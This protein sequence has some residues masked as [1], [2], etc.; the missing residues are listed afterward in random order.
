MSY[1]SII[2]ELPEDLRMVMLRLVEAVQRDMREQFAVR[3]EDFEH[4]QG[5][6]AQ[7]A[8]AYEHVEE[9]LTRLETAVVELAEA[10]KRSEER[11]TRLETAVVELAEAQKRSE[12]RLTRLETVVGRLETVVVELAEVQKRAEERLGSLEAAVITMTAQLNELT[13]VVKRA[14]L[15]EM[16]GR[17]LEQHYRERAAAYFG[18]VLR[19]V[20]VV[21]WSEI[22][23][24]VDERLSQNERNDL[25][26][27][28]LLVRGK[29]RTR[30]E[31][32][33]VWVALEV[34]GQVEDYDVVRAQ[35]RAAILQR[36]GYASVPAVAGE[37][38]TSDGE[39]SAEAANVVVI[40]NGNMR[41]WDEALAKMPPV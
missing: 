6:V 16:R 38:I 12:E 36:L 7:L 19:R 14:R 34:S 24:E 8:G 18:N 10:Q 20:R 37:E 26:R 4:L 2:E 39:L 21:P 30:P 29:S 32:P 28:D 41:F 31:L 1:L 5:V 27:L 22:E 15:D 23:D 40:Q 3:R 11:L 13:R 9:R 33:E 17:F 35:R 25:L